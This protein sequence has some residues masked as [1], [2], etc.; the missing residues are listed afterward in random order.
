MEPLE[1][2]AK[3]HDRQQAAEHRHQVN[4][5][6]S[7]VG[8]QELYTS[9]ITQIGQD[10]WEQ[11]RIGDREQSRCSQR[12]WLDCQVFPDIERQKHYGSRS[13]CCEQEAQR[14]NLRTAAQ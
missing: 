1:A 14:M 12:H 3:K 7:S 10:R 13:K 11:R 2:F 6:A 9:V 5:Q 8:A 4:K